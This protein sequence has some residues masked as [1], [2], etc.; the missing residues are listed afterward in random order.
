[1]TTRFKAKF[2]IK[3]GDDVVVITGD[4]KDLTKPRKVLAVLIAKAKV[5][6]EAV[7]YTHLDEYKR[8]NCNRAYFRE[9]NHHYTH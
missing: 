2:N 4:D 3:K 1:M 5:I 6:V 9:N 7:S 8:Q